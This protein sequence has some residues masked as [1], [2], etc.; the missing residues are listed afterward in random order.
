MG[1]RFQ[2]AIPQ[3]LI[4]QSN[5][6][7]FGQPVSQFSFSQPQF[8]QQ[9]SANSNIQ[10]TIQRKPSQ[11]TVQLNNQFF[12]SRNNGLLQN[13]FRDESLLLNFDKFSPVKEQFENR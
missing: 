10:D 3:K 5:P 7:R 13:R 6:D 11:S 12:P 9:L 2:Q 8:T 4:L 1:T